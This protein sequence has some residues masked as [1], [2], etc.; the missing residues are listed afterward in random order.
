MGAMEKP[1]KAT[2]STFAAA[3]GFQIN[4]ITPSKATVRRKTFGL[5]QLGAGILRSLSAT[6][7]CCVSMIVLMSAK[8]EMIRFDAWRI[9]AVMADLETFRDWAIRK[10]P[11]DSVS[12]QVLSGSKNL[13]VSVLVFTALPFNAA[14]LNRLRFQAQ[15][16]TQRKLVEL[17]IMLIVVI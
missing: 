12:S 14:R 5:D 10:L 16:L 9:V 3:N 1:I 4:K 6:F 7:P 13:A 2:A 15:S 11:S 8:E 17:V